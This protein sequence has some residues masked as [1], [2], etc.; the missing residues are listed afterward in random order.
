M[1]ER[2][3][4]LRGDADGAIFR[5]PDCTPVS[6]QW[7]IERMRDILTALGL[8]PD[9]YAGHS[10]WIGAATMA[11]LAGVEDS[12]IQALG[13]WHSAAFVQYIRLPADQLAAISRTLALSKMQSLLPS[14]N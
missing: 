12:T 10:F 8:P 9:H 5:R 6:K 2:D 11:A 1:T 3:I 14:L 13:R 4:H 7:F